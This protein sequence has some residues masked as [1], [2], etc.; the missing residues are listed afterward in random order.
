MGSID[1]EIENVKDCN[2]TTGTPASTNGTGW[3]SVSIPSAPSY[4]SPQSGSSVVDI[5]IN[6][7]PTTYNFTLQ[8]TSL[9]DSQYVTKTATVDIDDNGDITTTTTTT[10]IKPHYE[11]I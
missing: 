3:S 4:Y 10:V 9:D 6:P 11:E 1:W 7:L 8:C 5:T 2:T